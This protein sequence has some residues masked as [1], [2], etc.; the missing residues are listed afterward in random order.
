MRFRLC[1]RQFQAE[2]RRDDI[3]AGTPETL[4]MRYLKQQGRVG[5]G[6]GVYILDMSVASMH[7]QTH[8]EMYVR[9]A[10]EERTCTYWSQRCK[11]LIMVRK[12]M[13]DKATF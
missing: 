1:V 7:A 2:Q 3:F 11:H 8:E 13:K 4:F 5:H 6:L 9:R 12:A 10:R